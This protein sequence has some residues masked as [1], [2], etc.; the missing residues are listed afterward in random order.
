MW[1]GELGR[2]STN[3]RDERTS[4]ERTETGPCIMQVRLTVKRVK[5]EFLSEYVEGSE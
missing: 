1:E 3:K 5:W 2:R 4:L